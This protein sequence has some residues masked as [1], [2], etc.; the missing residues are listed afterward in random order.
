MEI[1]PEDIVN[2]IPYGI[3][4]SW[5]RVKG[6]ASYRVQFFSEDLLLSTFEIQANPE[7][8]IMSHDYRSEKIIENGNYYARVYSVAR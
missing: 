2:K 5:E 7:L 6:A 3:K 4:A 8:E 1:L